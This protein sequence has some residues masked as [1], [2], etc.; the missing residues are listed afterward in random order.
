MSFEL[1]V[2]L[3]CYGAVVIVLTGVFLFYYENKHQPRDGEEHFLFFL[4]SLGSAIACPVSLSYFAA[5]FCFNKANA[6]DKCPE[7]CNAIPKRSAYCN[8]CGE[9]QKNGK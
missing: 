8:Y 2:F 7:C 3:I 5:K 9:R 1:T 4:A 6:V